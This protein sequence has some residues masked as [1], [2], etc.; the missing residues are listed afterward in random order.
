MP[1]TVTALI[2]AVPA[3]KPVIVPL[4]TVATA[5]LLDVQVTLWDG[6][7]LV[8]SVEV[9]YAFIVT[10]VPTAIFSAE[11]FNISFSVAGCVTLPVVYVV[12]AADHLVV[13]HT[14]PLAVN[15]ESVT[16]YHG[17]PTASLVA[18]TLYQLPP[19]WTLFQAWFTPCSVPTTILVVIPAWFNI[20]YIKSAYPWHTVL[21]GATNAAYAECCTNV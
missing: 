18:S 17:W 5:L 3:V 15:I 12:V 13:S 7:V 1:S 20:L 11:L 19:I 8:V 9:T 10:G 16:L 14:N 21:L 2:V 4:Y 6:A